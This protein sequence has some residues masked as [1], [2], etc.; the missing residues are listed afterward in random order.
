MALVAAGASTLAKMK[1]DPVSELAARVQK[2]EQLELTE[3]SIKAD[4]ARLR[5]ADIRAKRR[6]ELQAQ[7]TELSSRVLPTEDYE[8]GFGYISR[9]VRQ[10]LAKKGLAL[11][12][13]SYPITNIDSLKDSIQAY[14]RGKP[15]K[16]AAIR[17]H[18]MKRARVLD[19]ADLIPEKWKAMS[20]EEISF[21]VEGLRS[22]IPATTASAE[23]STDLGK[24][25]AVETA[26][27]EAKY[28]SGKTQP[29][30]SKG[31]FRTVLAR[32]KQDL[33]DSGLQDV[34]DKVTETE[35]LEIGGD[36]IGAARSATDLIGIVDRIDS[37]ALNP[38]ALTNVR[39]S[40]RALGETIANLP[41]PFGAEATKVRF[42]DLP[43]ALRDLVDDMIMR[44]ETKI[45]KEDADVATEGLRSYMA[46]G[47][48]LNQSQISSE[49]SKMLRLLT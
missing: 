10:K 28:V 25:L 47:D 17:R 30:D 41:L 39:E 12:D 36:Y 34:I 24:A 21:A 20:S 26:E 22:R 4:D 29:R 46:G 2:L 6:S 48:F 32:I 31:K 14:G 43:P 8:D 40:A 3:L 44:V 9:E 19:R 35:N 37:G 42:S 13:G 23:E 38:Q 27:P 11:P 1:S 5:F 16:R 45:G 33:G 15:S 49:L 18:I 7:I